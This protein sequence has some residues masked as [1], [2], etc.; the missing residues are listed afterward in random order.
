MLSHVIAP[1]DDDH[2][3]YDL[4]SQWYSTPSPRS[5][6]PELHP[7]PLLCPS[8]Q[9]PTVGNSKLVDLRIQLIELTQS[10]SELKA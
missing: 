7:K 4:P 9:A 5:S 8:P 3:L 6:R 2:D 1:E 10:V